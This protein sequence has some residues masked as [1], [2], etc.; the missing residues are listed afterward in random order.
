MVEQEH[1]HTHTGSDHLY[2]RLWVGFRCDEQKL[3]GWREVTFSR[4]EQQGEPEVAGRRRRR[5]A[6]SVGAAAHQSQ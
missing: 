1:T 4:S 2:V 5:R 6:A 3:E